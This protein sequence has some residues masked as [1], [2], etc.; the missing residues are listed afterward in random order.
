MRRSASEVAFAAIL[1]LIAV[2][3]VRP[4]AADCIGNFTESGSAVTGKAMETWEEFA[5]VDVDTALRRLRTHLELQGFAI[6]SVDASQGQIKGEARSPNARPFPIEFTV[7]PAADGVR[8]KLW[9]NL[10]PGQMIPREARPSICE[11]LRRVTWEPP[12]LPAGPTLVDMEQWVKRELPAIPA[13]TLVRAKEG[14]TD[15]LSYENKIVSASLSDCVLTIKRTETFGESRTVTEYTEVVPLQEVDAGKIVAGEVPVWKGYT[16]SR[17]TYAV[18]LAAATDGATP[19]S[20]QRKFSTTAP[21]AKRPV[22]RVSLTTGEMGE[23]QKAAEVL[24][25]AALICGA[26][27]V[28]PAAVAETAAAS[29][30]EPAAA[31]ASTAESRRSAAAPPAGAITNSEVVE[32]IEAGLSSDVVAKA[33]QT[34][35]AVNFDLTP[36]GLIALK[37]AKVPDAVISAMQAHTASAPAATEA[38]K[39]PAPKYDPSLA[40]RPRPAP[41]S[42]CDGVELLGLY[43]EDF[44]PVSPLILWFAKVRNG[45]SM[46]KIV[47]VEW[48]NL[49]G[50]R[51][52][53]T[54]EV[55]AGQIATLQL[56]TQQPV[57]RQ[58]IDLR[59][60]ACR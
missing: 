9:F 7:T 14:E 15:P 28:A 57:E 39:K 20:S 5:G 42:P 37:K 59:L 56:A 24:R 32:M 12:V 33:V 30:S 34:A 21:Q 31:P 60:G 49:Y 18:P 54:A 11:S 43:K 6:S 55:G 23:A 27:V 46:T 38:A 47:S 10:R 1:L 45:T 3:G 19:F 58:P 16:F 48:T 22:R 44:R 25:R 29:S 35:A 13:Y 40:P 52:R 36:T 4:A 2:V 41:P 53:N 50:E 51:I 17:P 26:R 8:V